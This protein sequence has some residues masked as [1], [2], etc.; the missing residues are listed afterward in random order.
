[1]KDLTFQGDLTAYTQL[2]LLTIF[3]LQGETIL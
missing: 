2:H 3:L 1:M